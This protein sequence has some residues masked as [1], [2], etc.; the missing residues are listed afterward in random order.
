MHLVMYLFCLTNREP[1]ELNGK[2]YAKA[3]KAS[4]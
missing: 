3:D 4:L 2:G 1:E